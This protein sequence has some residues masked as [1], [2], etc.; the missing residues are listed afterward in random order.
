MRF[1][2]FQAVET[3]M[4]AA[5]V[6][7]FAILGA[8]WIGPLGMPLGAL[9]G[10]LMGRWAANIPLLCWASW[11]ADSM[12]SRSNDELRALFVDKP[13]FGR[14]C[15]YQLAIMVMKNRGTDVRPLLPVILDL[16]G[17]VSRGRRLDAYA[18]F[19]T[20]FPELTDELQDYSPHDSPEV[21]R[22]KISKARSV[23]VGGD[24]REK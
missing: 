2:W 4:T 13:R 3:V 6:A 12:N 11:M 21:C 9:A 8:L 22:S 5:G 16:L 18:A 10:G 1:S 20:G 7:G 15:C 19:W 14:P 24:F 23:L 17:S